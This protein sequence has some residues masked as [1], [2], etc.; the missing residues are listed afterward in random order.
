MNLV[1]P[2]PEGLPSFQEKLR[3][4]LSIVKSPVLTGV[5]KEILFPDAEDACMEPGNGGVGKLEIGLSPPSDP[6]FP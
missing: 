4:A 2:D 6:D 3:D 5:R 1:G